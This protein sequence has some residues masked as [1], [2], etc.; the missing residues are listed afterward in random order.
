MNNNSYQDDLDR[1][2]Q[3]FHHKK[4]PVSILYK[5]NLS[6]V[7]AKLK[8]EAFIEL[9][10]SMIRIFYE[11]FNPQKGFEFNLPGSWLS[12][13]LDFQVAAFHGYE[14]LRQ[15]F[16]QAIAGGRRLQGHEMPA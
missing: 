6:K 13:P 2:F 12:G 5:R 8:H 10:D 15:D 4:V 3:V 16:I 7:W 1:Y 11:S 14:L 9:N